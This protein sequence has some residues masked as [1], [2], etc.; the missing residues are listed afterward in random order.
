MLC[1]DD[2]GK[3]ELLEVI[4]VRIRQRAQQLIFCDFLLAPGDDERQHLQEAICEGVG[5]D[6]KLFASQLTQKRLTDNL[7]SLLQVLQLLRLHG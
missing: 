4:Q 2:K 6:I 5:K 1:F 3:A 7:E